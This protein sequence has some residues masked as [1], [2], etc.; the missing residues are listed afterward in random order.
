MILRLSMIAMAWLSSVST[1]GQEMH[2]CRCDTV[3]RTGGWSVPG[4]QNPKARV[5][6]SAG[7]SPYRTDAIVPRPRTVWVDK[8][9]CVP[10]EGR[11]ELRRD[12]VEVSLLWR[13]TVRGRPY[14]YQMALSPLDPAS[15]RH[16]GSYYVHYYYDPDGSGAFSMLVD[17]TS[18]PPSLFVPSWARRMA[19][20]QQ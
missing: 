11:I 6:A 20:E 5:S 18:I 16:T 4:V 12:K 14:A 19:E 17:I 1:I 15:G 9:M 2:P 3:F 10:G 7:T 8:V 13:Y